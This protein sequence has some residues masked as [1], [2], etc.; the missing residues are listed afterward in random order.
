MLTHPTAANRTH[1]FPF[2][3]VL[4]PG[5]HTILPDVPQTHCEFRG[6]QPHEEGTAGGDA[7]EEQNHNS[8]QAT[9]WLS[10]AKEWDTRRLHLT[11]HQNDSTTY[12][13][14]LPSVSMT[15]R[16]T[17]PPSKVV[18][19]QC[20]PCSGAPAETQPPHSYNYVPIAVPK[21]YAGGKEDGIF[22]QTNWLSQ[23]HLH[24]VLLDCTEIR[25]S[26]IFK[27]I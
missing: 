26:W 12:P 1:D 13:H 20:P 6:P 18:F 19:R 14:A 5:F 17:S 27:Q 4:T 21:C 16:H 15:C 9:W 22:L 8:A 2:T 25:V 11:A 10:S 7:K 24:Q 23:P 3:A